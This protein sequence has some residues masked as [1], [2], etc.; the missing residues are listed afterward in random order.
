MARRRLRHKLLL[1]LGLV[2]ATIGLLL[3]GTLK[4]L[5]SYN[6][7]MNTNNSKLVKWSRQWR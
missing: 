2:V 5:S 6:A 1:G 7:T 4:A 3:A